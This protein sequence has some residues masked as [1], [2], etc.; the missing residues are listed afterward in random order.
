MQFG[1]VEAIL[2]FCLLQTVSQVYQRVLRSDTPSSAIGGSL[3]RWMGIGLVFV[4]KICR[5]IP[6]LVM[7]RY[8]QWLDLYSSTEEWSTQLDVIISPDPAI[9]LTR[10]LARKKKFAEWW[11]KINS[12]LCP[13]ACGLVFFSAAATIHFDGSQ[14]VTFSNPGNGVSEA[15][16]LTFRF[17]TNQNQGL[18]VMTRDDTSA[19]RLQLFLGNFLSY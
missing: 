13:K 8:Y 16:I 19:D 4:T 18:L 11:G 12:D 6:E 14:H 15:E 1:L 9:A 2:H 5:D 17:R 3:L 10:S 7:L